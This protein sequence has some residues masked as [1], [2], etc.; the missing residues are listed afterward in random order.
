[1]DGYLCDAWLQS[2]KANTVS[3]CVLLALN[4]VSWVSDASNVSISE[5]NAPRF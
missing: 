1:M 2:D 5:M 4:V 3:R